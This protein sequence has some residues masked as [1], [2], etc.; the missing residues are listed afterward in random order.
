MKGTLTKKLFFSLTLIFLLFFLFSCQLPVKETNN[1]L[2]E[3][4]PTPNDLSSTPD[5]LPSTAKDL[6]STACT[7]GW[8]CLDSTQKIHRLAN[9][10][11][12]QR[13]TCKFGCFNDTCKPALIC[14]SGFTCK[15]NLERGYRLE[16]CSWTSR[17]KC[18]FGCKEGVC[19]PKSNES[20]ETSSAS[21][22]GSGAQ[23]SSS[24]PQLNYPTLKI[25]EKTAI[26][27]GEREYNLSIYILEPEKVKLQLDT[28]KSN[29]ITDGGNY[30]F[31][32]AG[33]N[34]FI[35]GIFF[36]SF[37]GGK[38]EITYEVK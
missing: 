1:S 26:T 20:E 7:E 38:R 24:L 8:A 28:F 9:C 13:E 34:I 36:Q 12:A 15:N 35:R 27:V 31:G 18:E 29:W 11:F 2:S 21:A 3:I 33:V 30:T 19:V 37:E 16:D 10:S 4:L 25:G 23:S 14:T 17:S 22:M 5:D 6:L 32:F